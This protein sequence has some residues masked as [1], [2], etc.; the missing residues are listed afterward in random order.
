MGSVAQVDAA[1]AE[2][3][4]H[5]TSAERRRELQGQIISERARPAAWA[6]YREAL[7]CDG[8]NEALL[9]FVLSLCEAALTL[10]WPLPQAERQQLKADMM[11]LL[12]GPAAQQGRLPASARGKAL[13]CLAVLARWEWPA[14]DPAALSNAL[15]LLSQPGEPR[16][17]GARLLKAMAE[18]FD[19][20]SHRSMWAHNEQLQAAFAGALPEVWAALAA[21]MRASV[22]ED[23][24]AAVAGG[25]GATALLLEAC[26][27]LLSSAPLRGGAAA[28][29]LQLVGALLTEAAVRADCAVVC[30]ALDCL[31]ELA[32]RQ[33]AEVGSLLAPTLPAVGGLLQSLGAA[34]A[35]AAAGG[36]APFGLGVAQ[37]EALEERLCYCLGILAERWLVNLAP[38]A[39]SPLLEALWAYSAGSS[40]PQWRRCVRVTGLFFEAASSNEDGAIV[41]GH[42][43]L[44]TLAEALLPRVAQL[45][46]LLQA[47]HNPRLG[48]SGVDPLD[49]DSWAD[50]TA[51]PPDTDGLDDDGDGGGG[52]G[53]G[54]GGDGDGDGDDDEGFAGFVCEA[55]ELLR[56]LSEQQ[57]APYLATVGQ[58]L[59]LLLPALGDAFGESGSGAAAAATGGGAAALFDCGTLVV[60]LSSVVG[61]AS[62]TETDHLTRMLLNALPPPSAPPAARPAAPAG[63]SRALLWR[64]ELSLLGLMRL[65]CAGLLAAAAARAD[66]AALLGEVLASLVPR[67]LRLLAAAPTAA[68]GRAATSLLLGVCA[69]RWP[70]GAP[71]AAFASLRASPMA[72]AELAP[73][74]RR[75]DVLAAVSLA[76]L[77]PP[78]EAAAPRLPG[79]RP[80]RGMG[81]L[82]EAGAQAVDP[83][84]AAQFGAL[85]NALAAPWVALHHQAG[86]AADVTTVLGEAKLRAAC[87]RAMCDALKDQHRTVLAAGLEAIAPQVLPA[88]QSLLGQVLQLQPRPFE[89]IA[90]LLRL[91]LAVL[92]TFGRAL[93]AAAV[94]GALHGTVS[95]VDAVLAERIGQLGGAGGAGD[96]SGLSLDGGGLGAL[97]SVSLQLLQ[98]AA[99]PPLS[100]ASERAALA[101]QVLG[102][103]K[104]GRM[105]WL[106]GHSAEGV[107]PSVRYQLYDVAAK[108]LQAHFALLRDREEELSNLLAL[109]ATG[110]AR[111][112]D[113]EPFRRCLFAFTSL[114][115]LALRPKERIKIGTDAPPWLK[116]RGREWLHALLLL[117]LDPQHAPVHAEVG[118]LLHAALVADVAQVEPQLRPAE[119]LPLLQ[120]A[121][122]ATAELTED[123]RQGLLGVFAA[124]DVTSEPTFK[125]AL[126][127]LSNDVACLRKRRLAAQQQSV[128]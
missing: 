61:A 89:Q 42:E 105:G 2:L 49:D 114:W 125:R 121:L 74:P 55:S 73:P 110:L 1:L 66:A 128:V 98:L 52:A 32:D 101:E 19:P 94:S 112:A 127:R 65:Q 76:L 16:R 117:R 22:A 62:A 38:H 45:M 82:G 86:G 15:Q 67:T 35:G 107:A 115:S 102:A 100:R 37:V 75:P 59:A 72:V 26:R 34:A 85:V 27:A 118:V 48:D 77:L 81:F 41:V 57:P 23:Q 90:A 40:L 28:A 96:G 99:E 123:E 71:Q 24:A 54:G 39:A 120:Q 44:A 17:V 95:A 33:A 20:R 126:D 78:K 70:P 4:S 25:G 10:H 21:G 106:L 109:L 108:V 8:T 83:S 113:L 43:L 92:G 13:Q 93:G 64:A 103:C 111:P 53:D 84:H 79:G 122:S 63:A 68:A 50:R 29:S 31:S 18:E 12:L 88:L 116:L 119:P 3:F 69:Q 6:S 58:P 60:C 36:G 9:W 91:L 97:F 14:E 7:L 124:T 11:A 30:G 47:R 46:A 56:H 80:G 87:L 5:S 104:P 51:P